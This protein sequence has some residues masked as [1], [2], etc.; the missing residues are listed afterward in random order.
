MGA[1]TFYQ[2]GKIKRLQTLPQLIERE[3]KNGI[4]RGQNRLRTALGEE[5]RSTS[6]GQAIFGKRLTASGMKTIIAREK[7]KKIGA[8]Y[9]VGVRVKGIAAIVAKGGRTRSH[10]VGGAGKILANPAAG[11]FARGPVRHPGSQMQRDDFTGRAMSKTSGAFKTEVSKSMA[12]VA[13]VVNG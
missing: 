8:V 9:E 2:S 12:K 3:V 6:V 11:F 7:V 1:V 13:A 10:T 4:R 5:F